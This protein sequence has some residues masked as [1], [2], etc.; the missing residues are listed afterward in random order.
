MKKRII[1]LLGLFSLFIFFANAAAEEGNVSGNASLGIRSIDDDHSAKFY[2]Y[3]GLKSGVYGNILLDYNTDNYNMS[4]KGDNLGLDDQYYKMSGAKWGLL[5]Y[6]LYYNEIP[7][8]YTFDARTF[9]SGV[10]SNNLNYGYTTVP[11]NANLWSIFDYAIKRKDL[12][13]TIDMAI[14]SPFFLTL[15]ANQ[16]QREGTYPIGAPSGVFR[17]TSPGSST[18][19]N[20]IEMPAPVDNTTNNANLEFGYRTKPLFLSLAGYLSE[21]EN[22]YEW[23]TFRNPYVTSQSLSETISLPP[24]NKYYKLKFTGLLRLPLDSN[25]A[26]NAG[27]SKLTTGVSLLDTIWTSTSTPTYTLVT[28]G[29]NDRTFDGNITYKN[30]S[31]VF[32]SNP[33]KSLSGKVYYKH[34]EK[35]NNSDTITYTYGTSTVTNDLFEY[36][37]NNTGIELGYKFTK[38]FK[39]TAGYDYLQVDRE[40]HD[41]PET[42]DNTY[43][44]KLKYTPFDFLGARI[45]YQ[46]LNRD[47]DYG[48]VD[49]ELIAENTANYIENYLKRF[50]AAAKKQDSIKFSIDLSPLETLDIT[51]EY[52]YKKDK[53]DDSVLGMERNKRNEYILDVSYKIRSVNIY[54][55]FDYEDIKTDQASRAIGSNL[56]STSSYD[57][58]S[59][60]TSSNYNWDVT[61]KEHNYAFGAG[62]EVPII[63]NTL[64]FVLQYD[65]ERAN[66]NADFTSQTLTGTLT[67][68]SIDIPL[69]DDYKQQIFSAKLKYSPKKNLKF[70]LGYLYDRYKYTDA[71]YDGYTYVVSSGGNA[72]T[73]LT[74]AYNNESYKANVVYLKTVYTF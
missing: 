30:F 8:N 10:G 11:A 62:T 23:L 37:K 17:T 70:I 36:K 19:G 31:T 3:N 68:D 73:Y 18:F 53:Y 5:K 45:K 40:R 28:L 26:V 21:F 1:L 54:G 42:T 60:S 55:Y 2:E 65:H 9:Y 50:D 14:S 16:L 33:V 47:A 72:N 69:Y 6:S 52:A 71:E 38:N 24:D 49:A 32:T 67:Q 46:R 74:G 66:G 56:S 7:H 64:S 44:I 43:C 29:L 4:V 57:P 13:A 41:V 22:E 25:L 34:M 15:S 51:T 58:N 20:V 48:S 35:D 59:S 39:A 63:S 12:G 27:Y 61:L